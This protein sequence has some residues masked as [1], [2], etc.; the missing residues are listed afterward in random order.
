MQKE[1]LDIILG[2]VFSSLFV[3]MLMGA[4]ILLFRIYL[5]RKN[6]LLLE[7]ERM[8]REF[9]RTL[10]RSKLEI[11]EETFSY[12]SRE[13]HDNIGQVLSMARININ[14]LNAPQEQQ[15][16]DLLDELVGKA[17]TDLR[18]LSHLLSTDQVRNEGWVKAVEKLFN[19][20]D[21]SGK[22]E[23]H[24]H[25]EGS[26]PALGEDK[27]I[28]LFRIIQEIINNIIKHAEATTISLQAIQKDRK[29]V[30]AIKDNGKGFDVN[31]VAKSGAGLNNLS[32]RSKMIGATMDINSKPGEGTTI[33]LAI[34]CENN[35]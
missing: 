13:I 2:I 19:G 15:K 6:T 5:K 11:Q 1:K 28:I 16:I 21:R 10:L 35:E 4:I 30:L 27:P 26:L 33:I 3:L 31:S 14:T 18:G 7:K 24:L 29:I 23:T 9:E 34:N 32:F 25:I 8:S 22:Y 17:I 12:I 20:L